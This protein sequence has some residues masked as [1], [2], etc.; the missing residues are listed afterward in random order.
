MNIWMKTVP[1]R[2]NSKWKDSEVEFD[3]VLGI[4]RNKEHT[5]AIGDEV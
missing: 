4:A 5:N 3:C 1:V 2:V